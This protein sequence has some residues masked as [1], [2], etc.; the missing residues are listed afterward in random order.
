MLE[1]D[2]L[3]DGLLGAGRRCGQPDILASV[4]GLIKRGASWEEAVEHM[5]FN[6]VGAWVGEETPIWIITD[7]DYLEELREES[8]AMRERER[9]AEAK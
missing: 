5:W 1:A 7:P 8:R 9:R 3:E 6:V 2:G 4:E